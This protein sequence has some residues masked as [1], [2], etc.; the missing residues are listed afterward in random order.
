MSQVRVIRVSLALL[1][2]C[3]FPLIAS[4]ATTD[5]RVLF[6]VDHD[7]ATGCTVSTMPGVDQVFTTRVET[8]AST[9]AVTQTFRQLCVG[10]SLGPQLP[11]DTTG[12]T[13]GYVSSSGQLLVE[14]RIPFA[15]FPDT[16]TPRNM[17]IGLVGSNGTTVHT[18]LARPNGDLVYFPAPSRGRRRAVAAPGAPR[19]ITVDGIGTDW[20]GLKAMFDGIGA[21]GVPGLRIEKFFGF[22]DTSRDILFFRFDVNLSTSAPFAANDLYT[23]TVGSGLT[24]PGV[25]GDPTVLANDTDPNGL[26]LTATLVSQPP[27]GQVVLDAN[28]GFVY[29]PTDANAAT[30]DA[31]EYRAS[32][33]SQD[34]NVAT[35]TIVAQE[36]ETGGPNQEP[37]FNKGADPVVLEDSGPQTIANWATAITAGP[38]ENGSQSVTFVITG[39][40]NPALFDA[41]PSIAANGT[42]TFTPSADAF[43]IATVHVKLIDDGGTADGG[44]NESPV[45]T[46]FITV[47][48][49]NDA[50]SFAAGPSI[51]VGDN[52]G[53]Q[54]M[55]WATGM[56]VGPANEA[57]QVLD[58]VLT[59]NNPGL[60]SVQPSIAPNGTITFTPQPGQT[61]FAS[62]N[63]FLHD[64]GGTANGGVDT[65]AGSPLVITVEK[66]PLITSANNTT[67]TVGT[68]GSFTVT[69]NGIP[70]PSI[71]MTGTL[72]AGVTFVDGTGANKGTGVLSGTP[73]PGTGG[74]YNL[75]FTATNVRGSS[76]V[77]NFTLTVNQAPA[78]TSANTA[79]FT[80][81]QAGTF[82]ITTTGF[83]PPALSILGALPAG[84]TFTDNGNGT[85]TI[86]G[87]PTAAGGSY[88]GFTVTASNGVGANANQS[89]TIIINDIPTIT[90][91]NAATF[92]IGQAGTFTVTA[93]GFPTPSIARGGVAL[94]AGV[95][96][97]D[98]GNGTGT[99][100][101]TPT[102]GTAGT[103]AINFTASNVAGTDGPDAFTLSIHQIPAVT[104]ANATTFTAGAAGTFTVTTSG[105]P[106][107][108]VAIGGDALPAGVT[109][110]DNG[111][112]TGTLAGT[113]NAGTGGVYNLTFTATNAAGSSAAQSFTLTVNEVPAVTSANAT[114]F[115][116][117]AAGTFTVTTNGF[118]AASIAIGGDAL[119]AGVTFTD[120]GNGTGTLA[121]TPNAGTGGVY[122]ITFTAT[123]VA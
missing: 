102:A 4:A 88:P 40:L 72:P 98:N 47:D 107:A 48:A 16:T 41:P 68:A 108:S 25:N 56:S 94:P 62:I 123:N 50:P 111:N 69:T 110:T 24:V 49:V 10:S 75:T 57:G 5:F 21:T 70:R 2:V 115:T 27:A 17:R 80:R 120:N 43:G 11:V 113:P 37:S 61:G 26:P 121:G 19:L 45:Q 35:V 79:T 109:F 64:D 36:V 91:A 32:N 60:F 106:T 92:V 105:F 58:F 78:I 95:T 116:A 77:Q 13:A 31:F 71:A 52:D 6:D 112:G 122:N 59:N 93:T 3:A 90:S 97:V 29:T 18:A 8:T 38:G 28:G 65:S 9:A 84:L 67:F 76:P 99:L 23:R 114:T 66:A 44:D 51:I 15:A 82:T 12:W 89:L 46:F 1:L 81:N 74:V 20:N 63:V 83:P 119:P 54:N 14:S 34:S 53:A 103:Y 55:P 73:A 104:S 117:G 33:G 7:I 30:D 85:A 100:S 42:L 39:V 101:G 87:T 22:A 86:G 96:Y 118:P